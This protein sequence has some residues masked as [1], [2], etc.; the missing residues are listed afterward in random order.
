VSRLASLRIEPAS[1]IPIYLQIMEQIRQRIAAGTLQA[2]CELP[3]VRALASEHLINPNTVARAYLELEREGLLC[4]RRGSGTY[5][6]TSAT[7]LGAAYRL[8]AVRDLLDKALSAGAEFG[9]TTEQIRELVDERLA[10]TT[11]KPA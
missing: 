7:V 5:V 1:P 4:K 9:F 11:E 8:R 6:S 10:A 3:S 2:Q